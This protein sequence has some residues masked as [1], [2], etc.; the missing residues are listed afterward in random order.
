MT[1]DIFA[2]IT[3]HWS[4]LRLAFDNSASWRDI[5]LKFQ[6]CHENPGMEYR[7]ALLDTED[8]QTFIVGIRPVDP[9]SWNTEGRGFSG[10]LLLIKSIGDVSTRAH[11]TRQWSRGLTGWR[12]HS[13]P[14]RKL[15]ISADSWGQWHYLKLPL[16]QVSSVP[17]TQQSISLHCHRQLNF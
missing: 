9:R 12:D 13:T 2:W 1:T 11:E 17:L 7:C 8:R 4:T 15:R 6:L 16:A 14:I 5:K 10:R 3:S